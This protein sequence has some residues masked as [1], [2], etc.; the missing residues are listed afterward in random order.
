MRPLSGAPVQASLDLESVT[1]GT[2]LNLVCTYAPNDTSMPHTVR[3]ALQ[4]RTRDGRTERVGT[5][6][7]VDG[8]TMHLTAGTAVRSQNIASVEVLAPDGT[9]VLRLRD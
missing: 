6:R 5:W 7:S 2:R 9:P 3:Y 1:W 4:V 8:M